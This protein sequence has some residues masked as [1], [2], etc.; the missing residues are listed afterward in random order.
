MEKDE[1]WQTLLK[2]VQRVFA[3]QLKTSTDKVPLNLNIQ[4][5]FKADSLDVLQIIMM[6]EELLHIEIPDEDA[7]RFLSVRDATEYLY[8][9]GIAI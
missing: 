2:L 5:A 4:D 6:I 8:N 9:K 1:R 3:D 7:V